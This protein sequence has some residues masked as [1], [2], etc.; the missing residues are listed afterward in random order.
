MSSAT[1]PSPALPL[2]ELLT[3]AGWAQRLARR[4]VE[5]A[6]AA[7]DVVQELWLAALR[8]PPQA[9]RPLRPWIAR[10]VRRLAGRRQRGELRREWREERARASAERAGGEPADEVVARAE[11]HQ[12]LGEAVLTLAEPLRQTV[13]WC[14]FDGLSPTQIAAR[15]GVPAGT[16]R[17]RLAE[18]R[19]LLRARLEA[20]SDGDRRAWCRA[21]L[22]LAAWSPGARAAAGVLLTTSLGGLLT[23]KTFV[24]VLGALALLLFAWLASGTVV[25]V[26]PA[27]TP[28]SADDAAARA[29]ID[30]SRD[31]PAPGRSEVPGAAPPGGPVAPAAADAPAL[32]APTVV[33]ARFVD[34]VGRAVAGVRL[35]CDDLPGDLAARSDA[36]GRVELSVPGSPAASAA[37]VATHVDF[38][39]I[40]RSVVLAPGT[41]VDLGTLRLEP[42]A[43]VSGRVI[44]ETGRPVAGADVRVA[45]HG[46][47][48]DVGGGLRMA[49][50]DRTGAASDTSDDDGRFRL[51]GLARGGLQV[52]AELGSSTDRDW[53]RGSV[54]LALD[55]GELRGVE[56]RVA[57]PVDPRRRIR[58]QVREP[59]GAPVRW[60]MVRLEDGWRST[61]GTT[62]DERGEVFWH[63]AGAGPFRVVVTDPGDRYAPLAIEDVQAGADLEARFSPPRALALELRSP[64]GP[65]T[66]AVEVVVR[67]LPDSALGAMF[68][69]PDSGELLQSLREVPAEGTVA[70]RV[71]ATAF[72][73]SVRAPGHR[74]ARIGPLAPAAVGARLAVALEPC[75]TVAGRVVAG[76]MPVAGAE[77]T[78]HRRARFRTEI[79]GFPVWLDPAP[80][81]RALTG[82]DGRYELTWRDDVAVCVRAVADGFAVAESEEL[83]VGA[84][85]D[86]VELR[87]DQGGVLEGRAAAGAGPTVGISRGDGFARSARVDADGR[88]RF[89]RVQPGRY[90]VR[91]MAVEQQPGQQFAT[92]LPLPPHRVVPTDCEVFAGATTV[93]DLASGAAGSAALDLRVRVGG[94][95]LA[96]A[97]VEV[98]ASATP[99]GDAPQSW[100]HGTLDA[101]GS[102][103]LEHLAA[104]PHRVVVEHA[105]LRI[106]A[107]VALQDGVVRADL[108]WPATGTVVVAD[109]PDAD[110]RATWVAPFA[111]LRCDPGGATVRFALDGAGAVTLRDVPAGAAA[112][113]RAPKQ[114]E[115]VESAR[116]GAP[117][118]VVRVRS[119]EVAAGARTDVA[120]P[121]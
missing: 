62:A 22:P 75:A 74:A 27:P 83:P 76:G 109:V 59:A 105:G 55:G 1:P 18:A 51:D 12:R 115:L 96:G 46:P 57:P 80:L 91:L 2:D 4:L 37:L 65:V 81:D 17:W 77:L 87:L 101:A 119:F 60:A 78:L 103:R 67:G 3:H 56:L 28:E 88:Y 54:E 14:Y 16:V 6:A 90:R 47:D 26:V 10:V 111:F 42:G 21:L 95:S 7:D 11:A 24:Q 70:L 48:I 41:H 32:A 9:D 63:P 114:D 29:T 66:E 45:G 117:L 61:T 49:S 44:D 31:D 102:A 116:S 30:P 50:Q 23:M 93:F 92:S 25:R 8:R 82:A 39:R 86:A 58:I 110:V 94:R 98:A 36:D 64:R 99:V 40:A 107:E 85:A 73:V 89:E 112:L 72:V 84:V 79:D 121:R 68:G 52:V 104:G 53:L 43:A 108:D 118:D 35:A 38:A 69:G 33:R 71:P 97:R 15:Q 34:P 120:F 20:G 106:E 113:E 19:R 13:L 5:D 100:A